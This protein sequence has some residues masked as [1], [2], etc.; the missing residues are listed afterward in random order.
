[1]NPISL[2]YHKIQ[3]KRL[4]R[5]Y[6]S[7]L[8]SLDCGY[9]LAKYSSSKVNQLEEEMDTHITKIN[10]LDNKSFKLFSQGYM[11]SGIIN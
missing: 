11:L 10:E 9:E 8:S 4:M 2:S 6:R 7:F 3:L 5:E 1:M